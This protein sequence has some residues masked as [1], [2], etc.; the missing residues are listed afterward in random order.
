[1]KGLYGFGLSF[2]GDYF[3]GY[4]QKYAGAS[5]RNFYSEL[6]NSLK[7]IQ[8]AISRKDVKFYHRKYDAWK[9]KGMLV[10]C[11]PPYK[12]TTQYKVGDFDHEKFWNVMR[13]W[14][15]D[16]YVFVSEETAP[17]DF[18][19]V[20]KKPKLRSLTPIKSKMHVSMEKVFVFS[21]G[22]LAKLKS[23]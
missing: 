22:K 7:S 15:K 1:M 18:K 17:K 8:G 14:S 23:T 2:G 4:I 3:S 10:Y 19:C 11:D 6:K 16:N 5:G 21:G 9:P 12:D 20:W 13:K